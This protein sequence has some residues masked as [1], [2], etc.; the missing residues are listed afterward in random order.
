MSR[1]PGALDLRLILALLLG[2]YGVVL[3]VLGIAFTSRQD[4]DKAAG[5]NINLWTGIALVV[6]AGLLAAWAWLRPLA[7]PGDREN[8]D[9]HD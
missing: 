5:T 7:I 8:Q 1:K 3:A 6:A 4:I 9:D 2:I